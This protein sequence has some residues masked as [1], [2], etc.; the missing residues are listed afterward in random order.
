MTRNRA[1]PTLALALALAAPLARAEEKAAP[2]KAP[3]QEE[4]MKA[5]KAYATPGE[6]Q[7]KLDAFAG[8]W[9]VKMKSWM[10]PGTPPEETDGTAENTWILGG[11]YLSQKYVGKMMG[12]PFNGVGYTGFD[13]YKKRYQS[14]WMD[15]AGTGIMVSAGSFDKTGKVLRMTA[16]MDDFMTGKKA[17]IKETL[18]IVDPDTHRL[19][20]WMPGPDGKMF[21]SLEGVYTRKK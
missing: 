13:N 11:R 2:P 10:A 19:E 21:K 8:S 3:T 15:D 18:T 14:V 6:G 7:K 20:M 9:N 1:F 12:Q 5:W 4:M 16:T 17:T